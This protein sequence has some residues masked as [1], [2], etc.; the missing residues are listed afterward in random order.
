MI[1]STCQVFVDALDNAP[2]HARRALFSTLIDS[3]GE[4]S[5]AIITALLLRRAVSSSGLGGVGPE[6]FSVN[7]TTALVEFVHQTLHCSRAEAQVRQQTIHNISKRSSCVVGF[8]KGSPSRHQR[9]TNHKPM[10]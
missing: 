4:E 5:R 7:D 6:A 9:W 3:L 1:D 8:E 10:T 2:V